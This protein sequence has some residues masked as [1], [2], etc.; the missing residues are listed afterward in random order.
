MSSDQ[1]AIPRP[2]VY[3]QDE[4]QSHCFSCPREIPED[5]MRNKKTRWRRWVGVLFSYRYFRE[6]IPDQEVKGDQEAAK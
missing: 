2:F 5:K 6:R 3:A 4:G 1:I